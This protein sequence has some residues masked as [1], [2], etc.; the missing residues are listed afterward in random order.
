MTNGPRRLS[1]ARA[2]VL[3]HFAALRRHYFIDL[4]G[5]RPEQ[6]SLLKPPLLLMLSPLSPRDSCPS[7]RVR[8]QGSGRVRSI[9][10]ATADPIAPKPPQHLQY[11]GGLPPLLFTTET[12]VAAISRF[13]NTFLATTTPHTTSFALSR[14]R[15]TCSLPLARP[16]LCPRF[17]EA[18]SRTGLH[19]SLAARHNGHYQTLIH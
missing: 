3:S 5:R 11:S 8:R 2:L 4:K 10:S 6:S 7:L 1:A 16:R 15:G 17:A 14:G 18:P 12:V 13:F 19:S 9:A